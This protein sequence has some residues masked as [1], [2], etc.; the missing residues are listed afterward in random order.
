MNLR[1]KIQVEPL[2]EERV[3]NIERRVVSSYADA[4]ARG[5]APGARWLVP[6]L[7]AAA[8]A[9]VVAAVLVWKLRPAHEASTPVA[10]APVRVEATPDGSTLDIGDATI[11]VTPGGAFAV[12]RP[13][14]GV[15]VALDHGKVELSVASRKGRA[16]LVV[17]AGDVDVVVVGT[18]FSVERAAEVV[19]E[20]T[21]G[22]VRVRRGDGE[23]KV[24]AGERW[25]APAQ[26]A[27][28]TPMPAVTTIKASATVATADTT[29]D[30]IEMSSDTGSAG[31][32]DRDT[33]T[34]TVIK[35]RTPRKQHTTTQVEPNAGSGSGSAWG[36]PPGSAPT[37]DVEAARHDTSFAKPIEFV[38]ADDAAIEKY[39]A[40]LG[41]STTDQLSGKYGLAYV[42]FKQG[43][44][45][46]ALR[47][48]DAYYTQNNKGPELESVLWMRVVI[49]CKHPVNDE[50]RKAANT[51]VHKSHFN[52]DRTAIANQ[53][54][55]TID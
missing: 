16:P 34:P 36:G 27:A 13:D 4:L 8:A 44:S 29:T 22:V 24:A 35:D 20:V 6:A 19:V 30:D 15:L 17:R 45:Q 49:L 26:I 21:E 25:A 41:K 31:L 10:A 12:T 46:L 7:A 2:D 47:W 55:N 1:G 9:A 11:G 40:M 18:K 52:A 33:T 53:L 54:I 42:Y 5:R 38:A 51:Y 28:G 50:C 32:H 37:D 3:V 23:V 43:K 39:K 14:G 48:L